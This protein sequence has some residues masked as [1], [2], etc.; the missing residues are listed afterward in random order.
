MCTLQ[1]HLQYTR[2]AW[3]TNPAVVHTGLK[4]Q[5][6]VGLVS[7]HN[8]MMLAAN[9]E[10]PVLTRMA[11]QVLTFFYLS[12][13]KNINLRWLLHYPP[14]LACFHIGFFGLLSIEIQLLALAPLQAY[15]QN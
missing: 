14:A 4:A 7:D 15:F 3:V 13:N 9:A 8:L 10:H 2:E 1:K 6:T 11:N 12:P 5:P